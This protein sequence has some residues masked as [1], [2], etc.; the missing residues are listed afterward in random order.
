MRKLE[1]GDGCVA[2]QGEASRNFNFSVRRTKNATLPITRGSA[3][4]R[5][6]MIELDGRVFVPQHRSHRSVLV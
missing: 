2:T 5:E 4:V 3:A 1:K 6:A